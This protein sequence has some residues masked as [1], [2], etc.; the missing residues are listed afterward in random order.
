MDRYGL[1]PFLT[2]PIAVVGELLHSKRRSSPLSP[3]CQADLGLH[4]FS[5]TIQYN[6]EDYEQ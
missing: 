5:K 1:T 3:W 6:D 4:I 2:L